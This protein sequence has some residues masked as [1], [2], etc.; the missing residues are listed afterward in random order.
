MFPPAKIVAIAGRF[1]TLLAKAS[2]CPTE[3][4]PKEA[5]ENL[6][7]DLGHYDPEYLAFFTRIILKNNKIS[8]QI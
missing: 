2:Y 7:N 3:K 6:H 4:T 1:C 5:I 8:V